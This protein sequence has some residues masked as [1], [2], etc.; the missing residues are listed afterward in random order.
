MDPSDQ[1]RLR[2]GALDPNL[3]P[4]KLQLLTKPNPSLYFSNR[5]RLSPHQDLLRGAERVW[6]PISEQKG[7]KVFPWRR[8]TQ[9]LSCGAWAGHSGDGCLHHSP[10]PS[11]G[12]GWALV[13]GRETVPSKR[14][15]EQHLPQGQD[16]WSHRQGQA[17]RGSLT[18]AM[19]VNPA[20]TQTLKPLPQTSP[21][22][23][24]S[25]AKPGN[26]GVAAV[27]TAHPAR[28]AGT[29]RWGADVSACRLSCPATCKA[30]ARPHRSVSTRSGPLRGH[31]QLA[32]SSQEGF[33]YACALITRGPSSSC[34]Q[35]P[36]TR[37]SLF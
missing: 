4:F 35:K 14:V 20:R 36:S 9:V 30:R 17:Q 1:G 32:F 37:S 28:S 16:P 24:A 33:S 3:H 31:T 2:S 18:P 27:C 5:T 10:P 22:H 13:V 21:G 34:P 12:R 11:S 15:R 26:M 29:E 6:H 25:S 23:A 7:E 8:Q 19:K